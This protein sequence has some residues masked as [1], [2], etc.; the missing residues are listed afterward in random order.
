MVRLRLLGSVTV[1]DEDGLVAGILSRRHPIALLAILAATPSPS[2]SRSKV[3]SLLW[4]ET[5]EDRA[6]GRLNTC[7][8][9]VRSALSEEAV[10]SVG[11]DLRLDPDA[12]WSD[13]GAFERLLEE[14]EPE[15]AVALYDGPFLD[16]F[17]LRGSAPF[18]K[19]SDA[20]RER[21]EHR[22]RDAL[23]AL[24]TAA[25]ERGDG[26]SAVAWWRERA[27]ADPYNGRV[28][29]RLAQALALT[30]NRA[31]ALRVADDHARLLREE[32]G[33]EPNPGIRSLA[34]ELREGAAEPTAPSADGAGEAQEAPGGGAV[35]TEGRAAEGETPPRSSEADGEAQEGASRSGVRRATLVGA[36]AAAAFLAWALTVGPWAIGSTGKDGSG[37][38]RASGGDSRS[39]V[40]PA[41]AVLPFDTLE[42]RG[43]HPF[44]A[45]LHDG[46]LTRLSNVSGLRVISATS[47]VHY[48]DASL[49]LPAIAESL[50]VD[51]IV[52]GGV[53]RS[54]DRIQVNAQLIDPRSDTHVWAESYRRE[55]TGQNLFGIQSEIATAIT[56]ALVDRI[57]PAERDRLARDP[58]D[59]LEAYRLYVEGRRLLNQRTEPK[60]R[61]ALDRFQRAIARDSSFALAWAGL[62]DAMGIISSWGFSLPEGL[63]DREAAARRALEL[64]PELAEAHASLGN[65]RMVR[66]DVGAAIRRFERAVELRPSYAHAHVWLGAAHLTAGD[67]EAAVEAWERSAALDPRSRMTPHILALAYLYAGRYEEALVEAQ[68]AP[69]LVTT[70]PTLHLEAWILYHLG[71][72]EEAEAMLRDADGVQNRAVLALTRLAA[73]D[74]ARAREVLEELEGRETDA[75]FWVGLVR[76]G[77]GDVEGAFEAFGRGDD[78]SG[79]GARSLRYLF[80]EA[81]GPVRADPRYAALI[82]EIDRRN[83]LEPATGSPPPGGSAAAPP[84]SARAPAGVRRGRRRGSRRGVRPGARTPSRRPPAGSAASRAHR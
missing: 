42:S 22:Y 27:G 30:G 15:E 16:G 28:A 7:L 33:V 57:T 61:R 47:V 3:V 2:V 81:L 76:A 48:G 20:V 37:R 43:A 82:R 39:G 80:P 67:V 51:W 60:M 25:E 68:R 59:D 78:L 4:P 70:Y 12:V 58:T 8:H 56:G 5:P 23:E 32:L 79:T 6:R 40:A 63:P 11:D 18:E 66:D 46:L 72:W 62:A 74:T 38:E 1:E 24:A 64:D 73:G 41:V 29:A 77:L 35:G 19:W 49:P 71:R 83:G 55:L 9:R 36:V 50:G 31:E 45:G 10:R 84:S 14:G 52:E 21:L 17:R 34:T 65:I 53:Q 44:A 26:E 75:D 69:E 13:V 54:G